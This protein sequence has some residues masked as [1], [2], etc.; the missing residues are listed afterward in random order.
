MSAVARWSWDFQ[1]SLWSNCSL[2]IAEQLVANWLGIAYNSTYLGTHKDLHSITAQSET[3]WLVE[4]DFLQGL[5]S[6]GAEVDPTIIHHLDNHHS[7]ATHDCRV[8]VCVLMWVINVNTK[9]QA[10]EEHKWCDV[11]V[12]LSDSA[13]KKKRSV[14][15]Q[16]L[17]NWTHWV[18]RS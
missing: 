4:A 16:Q 1:S 8:C 14:K 18:T 9:G 12:S 15:W 5:H 6:D 10:G 11:T 17:S 2:M 3:L 13:E 7:E